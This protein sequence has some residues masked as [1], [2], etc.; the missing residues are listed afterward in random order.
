MDKTAWIISFKI[1]DTVTKDDFIEATKHLHDNVLSKQKGFISWEQYLDK[2]GTW[3]DFVL[4][5]TLED[6]KAA[7]T[8]GAGKEEAKKFYAMLKMETCVMNTSTFVKKY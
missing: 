7:T 4:W 8:A 1:K 6:A 5:E 2:D 3:T